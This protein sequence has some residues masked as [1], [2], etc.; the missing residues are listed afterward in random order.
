MNNHQALKY[1]QNHILEICVSKYRPINLIV[2]CIFKK[3]L[4]N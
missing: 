4:T 2:Y 3:V 1:E